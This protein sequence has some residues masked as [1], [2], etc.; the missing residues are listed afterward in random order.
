MFK[1]LQRVKFSGGDSDR[2]ERIYGLE[3][4]AAAR[5]QPRRQD[6]T[7]ERA[8]TTRKEIDVNSLI[9]KHS[10]IVLQV[11]HTFK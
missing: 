7:E 2:V 8:T 1:K 6:C 3:E 11:P 4:R 9:K 10:E 5:A